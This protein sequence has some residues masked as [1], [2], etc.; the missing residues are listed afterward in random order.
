MDFDNKCR[1]CLRIP[2]HPKPLFSDNT[3][4]TKIK[5]ISSV[6]IEN[7]SELPAQICEECFTNI[8]HFYNFRKVI[9]NTE[10]DLR[11]RL[12]TLKK[13]SYTSKPRSRIKHFELDNDNASDIYIEIK[14]EP[15]LQNNID[16]SDCENSPEEDFNVRK[17][18]ALKKMFK[19]RHCKKIFTSRYKLHNHKRTK[20][21]SPGICNICGSIVRAD[22]LRKHIKMHSE[23]PCTCK[24]CG[25]TFKNSESLRSHK[26]LHNEQAYTC[27]ICGKL[28]KMKSEHTRHLKKHKDPDF[29]K[30]TCS[31]CG[32][33]VHELKRHMLTHTG[34]RPYGCSYCDKGFSSPYALKVHT[35]QHTNEKPYICEYC[36]NSFSQ[37]V[38]LVTHLKSKHGII[39][40]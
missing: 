2:K 10:R 7:I 22:N 27:E 28:F 26:F 12:D 6:E 15:E 17:A 19:C 32:K 9:I 21:T 1:T 39:T 31:L 3:L 13:T 14:S 8:I 38:S 33:K 30:V 4:L 25:K 24:E 36:S 18:I 34:E 29:R 11:T 40:Q 37:K 5:I 23:G 35:R 16:F 20:H